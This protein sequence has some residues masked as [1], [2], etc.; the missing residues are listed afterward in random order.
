MAGGERGPSEEAEQSIDADI[1]R[2]MNTRSQLIACSIT[3]KNLPSSS[4]VARLYRLSHI[5]LL[6]KPSSLLNTFR[7]PELFKHIKHS[8][9]LRSC[10]SKHILP[11]PQPSLQQ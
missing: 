6:E 4:T 11:I 2:C 3:T 8:Q 1:R 7:G 10:L 5:D 9:R